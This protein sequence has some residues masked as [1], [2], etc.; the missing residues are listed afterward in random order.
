MWPGA[1]CADIFDGG[2]FY[3]EELC[4][5]RFPRGSRRTA[6]DYLLEGG[7]DRHP[8]RVP[9]RI[10]TTLVAEPVEVRGSEGRWQLRAVRVEPEGQTPDIPFPGGW[11]TGHRPA[12]ARRPAP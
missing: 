11:P 2:T 3:P 12:D 1:L 5:R 10:A 7:H 4:Q 6:W 8:E 9:A